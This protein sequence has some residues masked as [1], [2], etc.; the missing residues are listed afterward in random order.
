MMAKQPLLFFIDLKKAFGTV[1]HQILISKLYDYGIR[2]HALKWFVSY[3][4]NRA[5][6]VNINSSSSDVK[7]VNIRVPLGSILG[8]LLII[9][10]VNSIPDSVSCSCVMYA[11]DTTLVCSSSGLVTLQQEL[12]KNISNINKWFHDNKFSLNVKKTKLT[13]FGTIM[14][15]AN[16]MVFHFLMQIVLLKRLT[17]LS[18]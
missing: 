8:P 2:N 6:R 12:D 14:F 3:L 18:I 5:Q 13:V 16:L 4:D 17:H 7:C 1:N 9:I 15:L 11:D 10:Y